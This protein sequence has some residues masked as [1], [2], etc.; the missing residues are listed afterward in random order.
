M[1]IKRLA[2]FLLLAA[3]G[4]WLLFRPVTALQLENVDRGGVYRYSLKAGDSFSITYRHSIYRRPVIEEFTVGRL[5][6]LVLI[7]VRSESEAV[8]EYFG[9]TDTR[10]FHAMNRPMRDIVFRV[11]V[12]GAQVLTIGGRRTSFLRL[13]DPGDRIMVRMTTVSP[14]VRGIAW[15]RGR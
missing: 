10:T 13:G 8:L 12:D 11:A 1:N 6:E 15:A 4:V 3:I 2:P 7:G 14:A 5:G 9:F